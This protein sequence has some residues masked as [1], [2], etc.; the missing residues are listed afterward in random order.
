M[1]CPLCYAPPLAVLCSALGI[2]QTEELKFGASAAGG[3]AMLGVAWLR[4][5]GCAHKGMLLKANIVGGAAMLA[6][7]VGGYAYETRAKP[8]EECATAQGEITRS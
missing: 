4:R 1:A 7:A 5:N 2:K 3:A 6:Y 8:T